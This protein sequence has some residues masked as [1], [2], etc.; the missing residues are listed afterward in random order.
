METLEMDVDPL[1]STVAG[2]TGSFSGTDEKAFIVEAELSCFS[3][4]GLIFRN[5]LVEL[6]LINN[7]K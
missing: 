4:G 3:K 7:T 1:E 6:E 2:L 5:K